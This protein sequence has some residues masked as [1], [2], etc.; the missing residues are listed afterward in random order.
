MMKRILAAVCIAVLLGT[1]ACADDNPM[2]VDGS[3][4]IIDTSGN[5]T[6]TITPDKNTSNNVPYTGEGSEGGSVVQPGQ[7]NAPAEPTA[8]PDPNAPH[9]WDYTPTQLTASWNGQKVEIIDLGTRLTTIRVN[10]KKQ[11][12][13]TNSLTFDSEAAAGKQLAIIH[14]PKSGNAPLR[15]KASKKG[16]IFYRCQTGRVV[17]V[18]KNGK[19]FCR[20]HY[21]DADGYVSTGSLKFIEPWDGEIMVA[22]IAY[23][24]NPKSRETVKVRQKASG[25]SRILDEFRCGTQVV[26]FG[27]TDRWTEIEVGGVHCF[28]LS[29]FLTEPVPFEEEAEKE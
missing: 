12:V 6:D 4:H 24:G 22:K 8:E 10:R 9:P 1:S 29:E 11:V 7:N 2:W 15:K 25:A 20:I 14:T 26:V 16:T 3:G 21:A 18:K 17:A 13:R 27:T 19:S 5:I 28:I 23:K